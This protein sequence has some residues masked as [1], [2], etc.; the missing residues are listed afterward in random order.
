M[1]FHTESLRFFRQ[2]ARF[3]FVLSLIIPMNFAC[4]DKINLKISIVRDRETENYKTG[5]WAKGDGIY[6][7][8]VSNCVI[9][10]LIMSVFKC[11]TGTQ[12]IGTRQPESLKNVLWWWLKYLYAGSR[13]INDCTY[14]CAYCNKT[15]VTL[16]SRVK[17]LT[18]N[19]S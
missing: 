10:L 13:T 18:D 15:H 6:F 12:T 11:V 3:H 16:L 7:S 14:M 1:L 8:F 4:T 19:K 9:T 17:T 5:R 2:G